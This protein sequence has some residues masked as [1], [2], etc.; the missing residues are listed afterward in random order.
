MVGEDIIR[1]SHEELKRVSLIRKALDG[2]ITQREIAEIL[3]LSNRQ[4]RRI[5]RRVREVIS[6]C[7]SRYEGFGTTLASE[8]PSIE[9]S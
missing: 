1:M 8:K 6:P 4:V 5:V 3:V 7:R 9:E 2:E